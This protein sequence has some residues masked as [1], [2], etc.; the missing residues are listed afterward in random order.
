MQL[1]DGMQIPSGG[2]WQ[3]M[4]PS[5]QGGTQEDGASSGGW[6]GNW[7]NMGGS[8]P[9]MGGSTFP[10]MSSGSSAPSGNSAPSISTEWILLGASVLILAAGLLFAW[11]F[12]R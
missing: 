4:M 6:G 7:G 8:W 5:T 9:Q 2:D 11:K 12:K 1:P 3:Q 10:G